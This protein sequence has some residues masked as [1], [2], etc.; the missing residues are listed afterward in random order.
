MNVLILGSKEFPIGTKNKKDD[1]YSSGG[2]EVYVDG[3]VNSLKLY[4][5]LK[6]IV[7][8]RKFKETKKFEKNGNL[9]IQRVP[10]IKGFFLRNPT[11]N[12]RA[13]LRSLHIS[14]DVILSN[15]IIASFFGLLLSKIRKK[16]IIMVCHGI[17]S[18]QPQY[19]FLIKFLFR[20]FEKITYPHA[21]ITITHSPQQLKKITKK[22]IV[23]MPGF[24]RKKLKKIS[25]NEI[26]KLKEKYNIE[27]K[28]VIIYIGRLIKVK[29]IEYLLKALTN[30]NRPY[31]C[32]IIGDGPEE[33]Y[34]KNLAEKLNVNVIFTGFKN[35]IN[36]FLSISD[37][38]VLPSLSESLNFSMIEA[39]YMNIPLVVTDLGIIKKNCAVIVPKRSSISIEKAIKEIFNNQKLNKKI[40]KNAKDFTKQFDWKIAS[41][42]YLKIIKEV[43]NENSNALPNDK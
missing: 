8:T 10:F 1:P 32:F 9:E 14:F 22:Y 37:I 11:F 34:L 19:N 3:L 26:K 7:I 41:K 38:F 33:K 27:N 31:I 29:G 16:P 5:N 18:E 36:K 21:N 15:D 24:N 25:K 13:F 17:A 28:K 4:K 2:V 43:T 35:D 23:I 40:T 39:A 42:K 6:L 20:F 30:I 12:L